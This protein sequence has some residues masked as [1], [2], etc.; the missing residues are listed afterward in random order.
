MI[1][2]TIGGSKLC[3][4]NFK[5]VLNNLNRPYNLEIQQEVDKTI[6]NVELLIRKKFYFYDFKTILINVNGLEIICEVIA[7]FI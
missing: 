1:S 4:E 7:I 6:K 5:K 2:N 3:D